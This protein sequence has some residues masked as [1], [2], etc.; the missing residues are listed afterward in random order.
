M[1]VVLRTS[2]FETDFRLTKLQDVQ[3][4]NFIVYQQQVPLSK[5]GSSG[6]FCIK[7]PVLFVCQYCCFLFC[8]YI[9]RCMS[10]AASFM[11]I[12]ETGAM[13]S[14][15]TLSLLSA[16]AFLAAALVNQGEK[17]TS[18]CQPSPHK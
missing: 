13:I 5:S 7:A 10:S 15:C 17:L 2:I 14:A 1:Y 18:L 12:T 11:V 6:A 4:K 16:A 9:H 3:D 8:I